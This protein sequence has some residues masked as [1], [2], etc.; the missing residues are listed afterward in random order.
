MADLTFETK[1]NDERI[2]CLLCSAFEGGSAY[3]ASIAHIKLPEGKKISDYESEGWSAAYNVPLSGDQGANIIIKAFDGDEPYEGTALPLNRENIQKG[4]QIMAEK[5]SRHMANFLQ[6]NDD[7]E[8][9][10]VFL[11]C[12]IFGEVIFG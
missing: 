1:V 3:W 6:E 12:V 4:L 7:A 9:G 11:Q 2:K 8:T 5:Y 10:D